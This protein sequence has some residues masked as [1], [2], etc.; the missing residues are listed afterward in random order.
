[1]DCL[2]RQRSEFVAGLCVVGIA[3]AMAVLST[4]PYAGAWND[5]SRLATVES[6]VDDHT[7]AIDRS[8][9]VQVPSDPQ[10]AAPYPPDDQLLLEHGTRDKLLI[11]GRFYSD[12]SPVPAVLLAGLYQG[13]QWCTGLRAREHPDQ[14]C[15]WMNLASA[16]TAYVLAV[17]CVF[18]CAGQV[19]LP[20]GLRLLVTASFAF[21]T[22]AP[23]Y[24]RHVNNH[25]ALLA[26]SL[27]LMCGLVRQADESARG[28]VGWATLLILGMLAGFGYTLD[29]AAGPVLFLCTLGVVAYRFRRAQ[30]VLVVMLGA[31]PWLGLHHTLNY[32]VGGTFRP[33]NAVPEYLQWPGSPFGPDN[34]TGVWSHESLQHFLVYTVAL[35][36]GKRGFIGHNLPLFLFIP[37]VAVLARRRV[38]ELPEVIF[39]LVFCGG[40]WLAYALTSRNYAGVCCSV[41]WFVPFLG[42]GY[43]VLALLLRE[44]RACQWAFGVLSGWG[45]ILG[46]LMWYQGPWMKHMVPLFWPIQG[47]AFLSLWAVA[48]VRRRRSAALWQTASLPQQAK[49]A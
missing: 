41:R 14:F 34:M 48:I 47:A 39:A 2:F 11:D 32:L 7:L 37:A 4:R 22:V 45:A 9:F 30:P 10:I 29:L 33:A 28:K 15:Y 31:L 40:T 49:A 18:H 35:L 25:I 16:G 24:E 46:A 6:L 44:D 20:L 27:L 19:H 21:S 23:A 17:W 8:I 13:L 43:Y 12:K 36:F 26:V 1:M 38:A 3:V 42:P 5:G